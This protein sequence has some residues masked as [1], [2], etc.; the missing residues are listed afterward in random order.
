MPLARTS[1]L[2]SSFVAIDFETANRA[3]ASACAIGVVRV[4]RGR[5]TSRA[6]HLIRPPTS[7]FEFTHIHGIDW[8]MVRDAPSFGEIWPSLATLFRGARFIAA[9]NAVFDKGV[10]RACCEHANLEMPDLPFHCTVHLA[11]RTWNLRPAT[12]RHVADYLGIPL[13]HHHAMSDAEACAQIVLAA[14]AA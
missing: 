2:G 5:I 3:P 13:E 14:R 4:E 1:K 12:L 7:A 9:H 11:R 10:L 8:E 6:H